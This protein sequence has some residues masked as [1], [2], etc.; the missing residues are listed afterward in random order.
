MKKLQAPVA[1]ILLL[2]AVSSCRKDLNETQ[3]PE[4][5]ETAS[6]ALNS[7]KA[8]LAET[9]WQ[10]STDWTAV[11]QPTYSVYYTNI[12]SGSVTA[13]AAEK[14]LI[15]VFKADDQGN[16][17]SLPFEETAG[18]QKLYWYYQVTEGNIMI[19]VDVYGDKSN[20]TTSAKFK[21]IVLTP[22][23]I[24]SFESK[25]HNKADLMTMSYDQLIS[26]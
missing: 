12:K 9:G 11:E 1:G 5:Q 4:F 13:D 24:N 21:N 23:T 8:N 25:G 7:E 17:I 15:R 3:A 2:L 16:S 18:S 22:E 19:A 10:T 26:E 14:G 6:V 20:P